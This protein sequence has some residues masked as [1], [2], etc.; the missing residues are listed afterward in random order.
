MRPDEGE[1]EDNGGNPR[2]RIIT[3]VTPVAFIPQPPRNN[4]SPLTKWAAGIV[5]GVVVALA[6]LYFL[7]LR[8]AQDDAR[9]RDSELEKALGA[10][11]ERQ[12]LSE[13]HLKQHDKEFDQLDDKLRRVEGKIDRLLERGRRVP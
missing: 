9:A 10:E 5:F 1:D 12:L 3:P 8:K 13:E 4:A 11:R 6:G 7:D 2:E